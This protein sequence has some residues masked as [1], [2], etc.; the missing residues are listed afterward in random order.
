MAEPTG[1]YCIDPTEE[2]A[3]AR[4]MTFDEDNPKMP[5]YTTEE[6]LMRPQSEEIEG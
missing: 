1:E 4:E 2:V 3:K 5:H 6:K